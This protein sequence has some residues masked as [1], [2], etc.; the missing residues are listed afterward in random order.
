MTTLRFICSIE[1]T[2]RTQLLTAG[3]KY[4]LFRY[5]RGA[6]MHTCNIEEVD[7]VSAFQFFC[8]SL[9]HRQN[10]AMRAELAFPFIS[11]L[12]AKDLRPEVRP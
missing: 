11:Q 8:E 6:E 2:E 1:Q 5:K 3:S 9:P 12:E 7:Q 10:A 4:Y